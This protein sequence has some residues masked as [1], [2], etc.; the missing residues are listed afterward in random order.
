[1]ILYNVTVNVDQSVVED[2]IQWMK[3]IHIPDVLSTGLFLENRLMRVL[4]VDE[5]EGNTFSVQYF[6][7]SIENYEVYKELFAPRL[8][9]EHIDRY[10]SLCVAFRTILET[11]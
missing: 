6:L 4:T 2:W 8:Q 11:V 5:D 9:K 1:M 10:G 3:T 7:E